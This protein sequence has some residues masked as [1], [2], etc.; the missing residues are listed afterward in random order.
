[1]VANFSPHI[2]A[3]NSAGSSSGG[4]GWL[5]CSDVGRDIGGFWR[6]LSITLN[7]S[8]IVSAKTSE[9]HSEF[10]FYPSFILIQKK[11]PTYLLL[12]KSIGEMNLIMGDGEEKS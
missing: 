3:L 6:G 11:A 1:M 9:I 10:I 8:N 2:H 5:V 7:D 12:S 4:G